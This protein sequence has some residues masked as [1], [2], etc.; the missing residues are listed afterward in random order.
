MELYSGIQGHIGFC[1]VTYRYTSFIQR[2]GREDGNC[3]L[4]SRNG[5]SGVLGSRFR[6]VPVSA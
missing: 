2:H 5:I 1:R 4:G 6:V 3:H